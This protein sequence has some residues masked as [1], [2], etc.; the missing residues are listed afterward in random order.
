MKG[1]FRRICNSVLILPIEGYQ[2]KLQFWNWTT[3]SGGSIRWTTRR[4]IDPPLSF[5]MWPLVCLENSQLSWSLWNTHSYIYIFIQNFD[6]MQQWLRHQG[7][8]RL[9]NEFDCTCECRDKRFFFKFL[10]GRDI[11]TVPSVVATPLTSQAQATVPL[12]NPRGVQLNKKNSLV[13]QG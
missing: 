1:F 2:N 5:S 12:L 7:L 11:K 13:P 10:L 6:Y 3:F 9:K 8:W 4:G